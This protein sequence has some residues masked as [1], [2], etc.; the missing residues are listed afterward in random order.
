MDV[1]SFRSAIVFPLLGP[2]PC[3]NRVRSQTSPALN[4]SINPINW[5]VKAKS[6][7]LMR[8]PPRIGPITLPALSSAPLRP[9]P[10]PRCYGSTLVETKADVDGNISAC[11]APKVPARIIMV[12]TF[13]AHVSKGIVIPNSSIPRLIIRM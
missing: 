5:S 8:I 11:A 4:N 9:I 12:R 7:W 13:G 10:A 1:S 6:N 2:C 3:G